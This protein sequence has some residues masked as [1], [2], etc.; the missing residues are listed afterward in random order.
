LKKVAFFVEGFTE[1]LFIEN[2]LL[3]V[4]GNKKIAIEIKSISGGS[5]TPIK[6]TSIATPSA[7][8]GVGYYI[9]IYNCGGENSIRSYISDQRKSLIKSGYSKIIGIRDVYPNFTH[10][11]IPLLRYGLYFKL[12]QK[13][14]PIVFV[15]GIM[16]IEAWFV[17]EETHYQR[18]DRALTVE[19]ITK[20]YLF[21]P[22][23]YNSELLNN[24][25]IDLHNIYCLAGRSYKKKKKAQIR[26]TIT[27]LDYL[28]VYFN[29]KD[30][31]PSLNLLIA[32]I[33]QIF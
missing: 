7:Q 14:I 9:L 6:I 13:A 20:N 18:I 2:L 4:F 17:A 21:N 8:P 29:V 27:N 30:R 22:S 24:P 26:R 3:E 5:R 33:D 28:N 19:F 16:E 12:P 25:A 32:E 31:I 1:Q 10:A 15:L 11:E 23:T